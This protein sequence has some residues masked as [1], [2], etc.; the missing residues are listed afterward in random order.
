MKDVLIF[1]N[2]VDVCELIKTKVSE[3]ANVRIAPDPS[4]AVDPPD[5]PFD[6]VFLDVTLK[7]EN[8]SDFFKKITNHFRSLNPQVQLVVLSPKNMVRRAI[9]AVRQGA[10]DHLIYP[11]VGDEIDLVLEAVRQ[12]LSN[13]LELEYLRDKFWKSE[14]L[15]IVHTN[16]LNMLYILRQV[17]SVAPTIATV[18]L[19]GE[20]G[21]GKGLMAKLIHRHSHRSEGPFVSVH[22][23]AIPETLV[24]SELFGHEK[25]AFTGAERRK[26]GKFETAHNGT[27]FLDEIGTISPAMQVKL[28][29]VLQDGTFD[30]I[31]GTEQLQ[32]NTRIIAATNIDLQQLVASGNFRNDLYYRLNVFPIELPP[33]RKRLEDLPHL[34]NRCLGKLNKKYG[35]NFDRLQHGLFEALQSYSW[36]GNV[37]ELEN[38]LERA[39][40]LGSGDTLKQESFPET[41]VI[42][43]LCME[44]IDCAKDLPLS[45][46]RQIAIDEFERTYL[47][48]LLKKHNG[49]IKTSAKEAKITTR[50][51]SRLAIKHGLDKKEYK[52]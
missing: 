8:F 17:R 11:I 52:S 25:G 45:E 24:E 41:L 18:L 46:A 35:K 40:I 10:D 3:T 16:N 43:S 20:T 9:K 13:K 31:G 38:V 30:R 28:L 22:C 48:K 14:W 34:I 7:S 29:H 42:G 12:R 2:D 36:P 47:A 21:T 26:I 23:G 44:V 5:N 6:I 33:L 4:T 1:C 49:K 19:L 51:F 32:T 39:C 37:R 27:L 50:Q 15:D